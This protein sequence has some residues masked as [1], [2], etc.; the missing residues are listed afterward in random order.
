VLR[1]GTDGSLSLGYLD[2]DGYLFIVDR[3]NDLLKTSGYPVWSRE[4]KEVIHGTDSGATR[5]LY[6]I[7]AY[8]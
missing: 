4:I 5:R 8:H 6:C 2:P 1:R 7:S 3:K